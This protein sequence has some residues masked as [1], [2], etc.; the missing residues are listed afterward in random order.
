MTMI[1]VKIEKNDLVIRIPMQTPAPSSTG[2]SLVVATTRGNL[3]TTAQ[4]NGKPLVIGLNA[5]ISK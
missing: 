3:T 5:Y 4:V 1:D 2:K